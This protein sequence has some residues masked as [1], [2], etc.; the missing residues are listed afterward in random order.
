[1]NITLQ[2]LA[3]RVK[4]SSLML[5]VMMLGA[6]NNFAASG[7]S[8]QMLSIVAQGT[9]LSKTKRVIK[10]AATRPLAVRD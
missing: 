9:S 10:V 6:L 4:I 7:K 5:F 3:P 1:V 2:E 8:A